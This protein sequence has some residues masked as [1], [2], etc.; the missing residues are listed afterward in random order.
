MSEK[1]TKEI[2]VHPES[3]VSSID[4]AT[5]FD[6]I[7]ERAQRRLG[8]AADADAGRPAAA[9]P[10]AHLD[11]P[12]EQRP[13]ARHLVGRTG[14]KDTAKAVM[15][16]VRTTRKLLVECGLE[17]AGG[18]TPLDDVPWQMV[19]PVMAAQFRALLDSRFTSPATKNSYLSALRRLVMDATA[20][21]LMPANVERSVL[22]HLDYFKS[23]GV[24]PGQ[25]ITDAQS[26]A[27]LDAARK[28]RPAVAARNVAIIRLLHCTGLR[29]CELVALNLEDLELD[30]RRG[31]VILAKTHSP[32]TMW[33][34]RS[35]VTALKS[36][37]EHR[38]QE[39]GPLFVALGGSHH[40]E[41]IKTT[42]IR[43]MMKALSKSAKLDKPV[44]S[45]DFRRTLITNALRG[46]ADVFTVSRIV[47]HQNVASTEAYDYR[48][49]DEDRAVIDALFDEDPQS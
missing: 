33:L 32:H 35:A 3:A 5:G 47:G 14:T 34:S 15:S 25:A 7:R 40:L 31:T 18:E 28:Q 4:A 9:S 8:Q 11:L 49:P 48:T 30:S 42:A 13:V 2:P 45:H 37:L 24:K 19:T 27:L 46:G 1:I 38:G 21:G 23:V 26:S 41:R 43:S 12:V 20:V 44:R 22:E 36:W 17:G 10:T 16:R 29:S 6:V 39:P